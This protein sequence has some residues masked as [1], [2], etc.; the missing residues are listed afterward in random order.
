MIILNVTTINY[1]YY[2]AKK[3][4]KF[5]FVTIIIKLMM[6]NYVQRAFS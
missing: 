4:K 2:G 3:K 5:K 1:E 6:M